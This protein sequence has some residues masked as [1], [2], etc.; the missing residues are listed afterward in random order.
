MQAKEP[1]ELI[2]RVQGIAYGLEQV[3][4]QTET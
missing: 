2:K 3:E 1:E 4:K